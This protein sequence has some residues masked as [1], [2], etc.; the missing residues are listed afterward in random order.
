MKRENKGGERESEIKMREGER[1]EWRDWRGVEKGREMK[2]GKERD[3]ER[4]EKEMEEK[5]KEEHK[6][7][8]KRE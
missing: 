5:G 7:E 2:S 3:G 1:K 4:Q 6:E 8:S